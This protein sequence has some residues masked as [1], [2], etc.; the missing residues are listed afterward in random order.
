MRKLSTLL[1]SFALCLLVLS[2]ASR[3]VEQKINDFVAKT[4][5]NCASY[6]PKDWEKSKT[7]FQALLDEYRASF[8]DFTAEQRSKALSAIEN[9]GKILVKENVEDSGALLREIGKTE[10][11]NTFQSVKEGVD[12]IGKGIKQ[13]VN[14]KIEGAKQNVSDKAD[15]AKKG[16]NEGLNKAAEG[17]NTGVNKAAEGINTGVTKAAEGVSTGVSKAAQGVSNAAQKVG[18]GVQEAGK[19]VDDFVQ[20]TTGEKK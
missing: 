15:E 5:K 16:V 12:N 6:T 17:I 9:Y 14:D 13:G 10:L 19:K 7:E 1:A 8:K 3:S 4:E 20:R 11:D 18:E 2:C